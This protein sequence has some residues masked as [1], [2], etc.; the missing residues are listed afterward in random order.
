MGADVLRVDRVDAARAVDRSQ[1]ATSAMNR[2]KQVARRRP[3][4]A[5]RRRHAAAPGRRRRRALRG[6]PARGRR[7]ARL[8]A[9]RVPRPQP[10]P[11]LRPA[12]RLGPGRTVRADGRS[13]HRLHRARRRARAPGP[14]RATADAADQRARRLRRRRDAARVRRGV[15]RLRAR[16]L[17]QGTGRST[18]PWSTAPR[19]C[20]PRSTPAR[21]SG[22]WGE[23]GTNLLDTGAPFYEV[24]ETADGRLDRGRSHRAPV[25]RR[26]ARPARPATTPTSTRSGTRSSGPTQKAAP[27]R[28]LP[29]EDARRVVRSCS[30]HRRVLRARA[31]AD[32][33]A[34][35]PAQ[36]RSRHVRRAST[37][38]PSPPL[39]PGSVA[40]RRRSRGRP[41]TRATTTRKLLPHGGSPRTRSASCARVDAI[42]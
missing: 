6:V 23:R 18:R 7:A 11:H 21:A 33:G 5:R 9:R 32:R 31:H 42:A 14:R 29:Y 27:G 37:T 30:R 26:A 16:P 35:P 20:S 19:S 12:D 17:G 15:R 39:R 10:P 36:P 22:F 25:L 38:C 1:P 41:R 8:R 3:Q 34:R 28:G 24:Y 2:G 4:A 40:R 13:R